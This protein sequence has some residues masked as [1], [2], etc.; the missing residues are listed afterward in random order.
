[1]LNALKNKG[2]MQKRNS[3]FWKIH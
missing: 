2:F 3:E 1:M